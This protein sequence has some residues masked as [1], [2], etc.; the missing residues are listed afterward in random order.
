M[1]RPPTAVWPDIRVVLL[2]RCPE[3]LNTREC[4]VGSATLL[5]GKRVSEIPYSKGVGWAVAALEGSRFVQKSQ[6]LVLNGRTDKQINSC[7]PVVLFSLQL[8][9]GRLVHGY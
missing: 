4:L 9:G 2:I 7:T 6:K 5:L 3:R 1:L 8:L